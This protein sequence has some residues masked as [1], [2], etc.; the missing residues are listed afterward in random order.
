MILQTC[1]APARS[2]T[3][4][5]ETRITLALLAFSTAGATRA[6]RINVAND[7]SVARSVARLTDAVESAGA[8]VFTTFD[9]A[10]GS[11][12]VGQTLPPTTGLIFGSPKIGAP[13]LQQGQAMALDLSL[14]ILFFEDPNGQTSATCEDPTTGAPVHGPGADHPAVLAMK[15]APERFSAAATS[16]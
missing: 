9:F 6:E 5:I 13:T 16:D 14:R 1:A 8:R 4:T 7:G 15:R 11:A 10:R 2:P 3:G 12:S